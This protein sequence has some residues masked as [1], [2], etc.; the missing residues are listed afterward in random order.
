MARGGT[1]PAP[2]EIADGIVTKRAGEPDPGD[3]AI[4]T[5]TAREVRAWIDIAQPEDMLAYHSGFGIPS[6]RPEGVCAVDELFE[7]G[8]VATHQTRRQDGKGTIYWVRRL[9][10]LDPPPLSA[11]QVADAPAND[12]DDL[13]ERAMKLLRRHAAFNL[14]APTNADIARILHLK[15]AA[16][17]AYL[18]RKLTRL[19]RIRVFVEKDGPHCG[20][21]I[22]TICASGK[23][24]RGIGR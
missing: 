22:I 16:A 21:R 1:Q 5:V 15:D 8:E 13:L 11:A 6:P 2:A 14:P 17:G 9:A 3:P 7:A 24:T 19:E 23:R 10:V 20:Q 18:V 12:G 4:D